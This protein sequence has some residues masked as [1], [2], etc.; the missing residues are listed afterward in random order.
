MFCC[1]C[2]PTRR[3]ASVSDLSGDRIPVTAQA[4]TTPLHHPHDNSN[5]IPTLP[6]PASQ[7]I[8]TRRRHFWET[9]PAYGGHPSIWTALHDYCST[10]D[11]DK[12]FADAM[13]QSV[14]VVS[15]PR[16][17]PSGRMEAYDCS[18]YRYE[19]PDYCFTLPDAD[20]GTAGQSALSWSTARQPLQDTPPTT[21]NVVLRF[22][23][24]QY[25]DLRTT[26]SSHAPLGEVLPQ[27]HA[28]VAAPW[29][30]VLFFRCGQGPIPSD[31]CIGEVMR[32]TGGCVEDIVVMQ[33]M[34]R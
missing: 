33:V 31:M 9:A 1:C 10:R 25:P 20:A 7:G 4:I 6:K 26:M 32:S 24:N 3:S 28:H 2:G 17:V 18:G 30:E 16:I 19:I 13:L 23:N 21:V 34:F 14:G 15:E 12:P 11:T 22:A 27:V 8:Y 5:H 29:K